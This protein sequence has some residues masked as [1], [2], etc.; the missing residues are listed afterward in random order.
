LRLAATLVVSGLCPAWAAAPASLST[1][2]IVNK[3]IGQ[4]LLWKADDGPQRGEIFFAPDGRVEMT[5]T[6]PGLP[7][8]IGSWRFSNGQ[9]CT[10]WAQARGGSEKCYEVVETAPGEYRTDG[11]NTFEARNPWI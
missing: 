8:D 2:A 1:D 7:R 6:M 10:R 4:P 3:L 9:L 11:G 5:T